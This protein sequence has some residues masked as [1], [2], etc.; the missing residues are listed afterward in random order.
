MGIHMTDVLDRPVS[1]FMETR[2]LA[3]VSE[4]TITDAVNTMIENGID[5]VIVL[6]DNEVS[7]IVTYKDILYD[8]VAKGRDPLKT[9]IKE[10][11]HKPLIV[12]HRDAKVREAISLMSK[13]NIRRLI[14]TDDNRPI[15]I[16]SQKTMVGNMTD[17]AIALPEL[18]IPNK[19]RC[20]YC[21]S[22]FDDKKILSSHI[23]SIHIGKGLFEGNMARR[24]D[25]GSI[26]SPNYSKTI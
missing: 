24:D 16:I 5:S 25:L 13:N 26:S 3:Q 21:S 2:L 4:L 22:I 20:P 1:E 10:I 17:Y 14:V 19:I 7:G 9:T 12:I 15:G 18:E 11:M 6:E 8:V 23:D